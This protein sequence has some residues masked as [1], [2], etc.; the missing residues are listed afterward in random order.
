MTPAMET[1]HVEEE[2]VVRMQKAISEA[3]PTRPVG[4]F[5]KALGSIATR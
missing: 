3:S 1:I 4:K 5:A 2:A